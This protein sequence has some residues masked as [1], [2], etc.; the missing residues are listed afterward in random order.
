MNG[1]GF[2]TWFTG[3]HFHHGTK[4]QSSLTLNESKSV[5]VYV[6]NFKWG[7]LATSNLKQ[8]LLHDVRFYTRF[9]KTWK[10]HFISKDLTCDKTWIQICTQNDDVTRHKSR[11][12]VSFVSGYL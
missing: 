11:H 12:R 9:A 7:P 10:H 5:D 1:R 4:F 8:N 2:S 6:K 3:M